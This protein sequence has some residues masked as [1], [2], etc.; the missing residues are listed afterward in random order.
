MGKWPVLLKLQSPSRHIYHTHHGLQ[1]L[2]HCSKTYFHGCHTW[3][4]RDW[5]SQEPLC[6]GSRRTS[7][8]PAR[9][10][11]AHSQQWQSINPSSFSCKTARWGRGGS[12]P[13]QNFQLQD[14]SEFLGGNLAWSNKLPKSLLCFYWKA[15]NRLQYQVLDTKNYHLQTNSNQNTPVER[16][17]ESTK[18]P[19]SRARPW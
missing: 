16:E 2:E 13:L 14:G 3:Q 9:V 11:Q 4:I 6:F 19:S 18:S 5:R 10:L 8:F 15:G 7:R 17:Y 12:V 1:E